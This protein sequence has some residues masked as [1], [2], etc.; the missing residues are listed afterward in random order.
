MALGWLGVQVKSGRKVKNGS[1]Q[2]AIFIEKVG[3]IAM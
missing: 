3:L 1:N 2:G